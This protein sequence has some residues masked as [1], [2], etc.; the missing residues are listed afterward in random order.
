MVKY[1]AKF[2]FVYFHHNYNILKIRLRPEV[3][4]KNKLN[5]GHQQNKCLKA[6]S[7]Y[8]SLAECNMQQ[9]RSISINKII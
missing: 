9:I 3:K 7:I 8:F 4:K 1:C 6:N 2:L 5:E